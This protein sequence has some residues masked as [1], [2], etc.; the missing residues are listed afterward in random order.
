MNLPNWASSLVNH[1][2]FIRVLSICK[3]LHADFGEAVE[4]HTYPGYTHTFTQYVGQPAMRH[5]GRFFKMTIFLRKSHPYITSYLNSDPS[6]IHKNLA[7]RHFFKKPRQTASWSETL[8]TATCLIRKRGKV[9]IMMLTSA[10]KHHWHQGICIAG[11]DLGGLQKGQVLV[12]EN[13]KAFLRW[14]VNCF[15]PGRPSSRMGSLE[16][17]FP[18]T[19]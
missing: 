15:S 17:R 14:V 3:E 7:K 5:T 16:G 2:K 4:L 8:W 1:R 18:K 9:T 13:T 10:A 6:K 12:P 19:P 11:Q